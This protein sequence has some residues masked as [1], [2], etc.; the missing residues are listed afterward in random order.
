L[1]GFLTANRQGERYLLST[2]TTMLAAPIIVRTGEAVMA[3]GG[4]HG[5]DPILTPQALARLVD[6]RQVRF[7]MIDDLSTVSRRL[8]AETAARPIAEWVRTH[9]EPV[10]PEL[11]RPRSA[12]RTSA[13]RLYDLRPGTTLVSIGLDQALED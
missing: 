6:Q 13:M 1:I 7:V 10:D 5:L 8:G 2:S 12:T 3:R 4:F 11:W 9:G